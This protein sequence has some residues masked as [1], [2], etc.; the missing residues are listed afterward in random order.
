MS[1]LL[2]FLGVTGFVRDVPRGLSLRTKIVT[3][4]HGVRKEVP[5]FRRLSL[6]REVARALLW[7]SHTAPIRHAL[8][9]EPSFRAGVVCPVGP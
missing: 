9:T 8:P 1:D 3:P 2:T 6:S 7:A 5:K 4:G